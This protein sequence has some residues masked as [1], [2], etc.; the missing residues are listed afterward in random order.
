ML[1]DEIGCSITDAFG[2][3]TI[4]SPL[5]LSRNLIILN[6]NFKKAI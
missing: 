6:I 3:F 4:M 1:R 2:S 5:N